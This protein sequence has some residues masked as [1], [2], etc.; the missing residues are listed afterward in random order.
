MPPPQIQKKGNQAQS[1]KPVNTGRNNKNAS[2]PGR[3]P[4]N[5]PTDLQKF[6]NDYR[7]ITRQNNKESTNQNVKEK[8]IQELRTYGFVIDGRSSTEY[9]SILGK[10]KEQLPN[11]MKPMAKNVNT[12]SGII[13]LMEER[14][15]SNSK[16]IRTEKIKMTKRQVNFREQLSNMNLDQLFELLL[17]EFQDISKNFVTRYNDDNPNHRMKLY[18]YTELKFKTYYNALSKYI[19]NKQVSANNNLQLA[20]TIIESTSNIERE[21]VTQN[22]ANGRMKGKNILRQFFNKLSEF[23]VL[24]LKEKKWYGKIPLLGAMMRVRQGLKVNKRNKRPLT[25]RGLNKPIARGKVISKA[26]YNYN[27]NS[28]NINSKKINNIIK[29]FNSKTYKNLTTP[30]NNL[31]NKA[32]INTGIN[33]NTFITLNILLWMDQRHDFK[34]TIKNNFFE[35]L[36]HPSSTFYTIFPMFNTNQYRNIIINYTKRILGNENNRN[37]ILN[38]LLKLTILEY[39][40]TVKGPILKINGNMEDNIK[41]HFGKFLPLTNNERRNRKI[42]VYNSVNNENK[43][44]QLIRYI[45]IDS[46]SETKTA[47]QKIPFNKR[48]IPLE[49]VF[50][51]GYGFSGNKSIINYIK[52][53]TSKEKLPVMDFQLRK[54]TLTIKNNINNKNINKNIIIGYKNTPNGG[55][56]NYR[57][58]P[59]LKINSVNINIGK[60]KKQAQEVVKKNNNM[61]GIWSKTFGDFMQIL[62]IASRHENKTPVHYGTFDTMS[63]LLYLFVRKYV[64]EK[65]YIYL[66]LQN[67]TNLIIIN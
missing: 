4:R 9:D 25:E 64:Y 3:P 8:L 37:H 19:S 13:K 1:G 12:I 6:K 63:A 17:Q 44:N 31:R 41:N 52:S 33:M 50:D 67:G 36:N 48:F 7:Y 66:V 43:I 30:P 39:K 59:V 14:G 40:E 28:N 65:K 42:G 16:N 5:V 45:S 34:N 23:S 24:L 56:T 51:P 35:L 57:Y 11:A 18:N 26:T 54:Y 27:T 22:I 32:E 62:A 10:L 15:N 21:D 38:Q 20:L 53:L 61:R 46:E 29:E 55:T 47:F 58:K 2:L 60:S 49:R